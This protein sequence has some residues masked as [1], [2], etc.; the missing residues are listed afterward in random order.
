MSIVK[1]YY[2][3][4]Y[5]MDLNIIGDYPQ[6]HSFINGLSE[7][8][9]DQYYSFLD[10]SDAPDESFP[11]TMPVLKGYKLA[12]RAKLTDLI[13][14][15]PTTLLLVSPKLLSIFENFNL[16]QC[17]I[18]PTLILKR[19]VPYD[20]YFLYIVSGLFK[21][22]KIEDFEF[23]DVTTPSRNTIKFNS[24]SEFR[25]WYCS[26]PFPLLS[27]QP[28]KAVFKKGCP[29]DLDIIRIPAIYTEFHFI[30]ERVKVEIEKNNITGFQFGDAI[31]FVFE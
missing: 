18:I 31:D 9:I 20:Y 12:G 26:I 3:V 19:G 16:G 2:L 17:K 21:Y 11:P 4:D 25:N 14:Q 29:K 15:T 22:I 7:Q 5:S 1:K 8:D 24:I 10:Y 30:S 13:S 27:P 23:P 28:T 6:C